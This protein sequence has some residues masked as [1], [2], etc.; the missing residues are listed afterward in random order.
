VIS[1]DGRRIGSGLTGPA[2]VRLGAAFAELTA[3]DGT[4]IG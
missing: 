4:L 1:V 2:T 3:T